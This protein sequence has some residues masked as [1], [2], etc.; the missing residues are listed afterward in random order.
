LA[1]ELVLVAYLV[2]GNIDLVNWV[3]DIPLGDRL[4]RIPLELLAGM[5]SLDLVPDI[6][7]R[8]WIVAALALGGVAAACA[9][10]S[11]WVAARPFLLLG[12]AGIL[13]PLAIALVKPSSDYV[14]PRYLIA[15]QVPLLI[16]VAA[17]L[18]TRRAGRAGLVGGIALAGVL[19]SLTLSIATRSELQR[20]DW[21]TVGETIGAAETP[22]AVVVKAWVAS[23]PLHVYVPRLSLMYK[24]VETPGL[25]GGQRQRARAPLRIAE[26][27][28]LAPGARKPEGTLVRGFRLTRQRNFGGAI[29]ATYASPR[30]V[31]TTPRALTAGVTRLYGRQGLWQSPLVYFQDAT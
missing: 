10:R 30:P 6:A 4:Q 27:V 15:A 19:L 23:L 13:L 3:R 20:P 12:A 8:F 26:I 2:T 28:V 18:G 5:E 16:V 24:A 9:I 25:E 14:L 31:W 7:I 21:R 17:G 29:M 1:A 11:E 22:R